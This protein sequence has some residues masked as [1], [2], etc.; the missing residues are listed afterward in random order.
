MY[1][2]NNEVKS[3]TAEKFNRTLKDNIYKYMN[4]VLKKFILIN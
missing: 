3:V 4:S 2:R 1:S